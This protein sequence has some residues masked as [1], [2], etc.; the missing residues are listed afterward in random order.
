LAAMTQSE[1]VFLW[2]YKDEVHD[3]SYCPPKKWW[4]T[5]RDIMNMVL[6][7]GPHE[8]VV[9]TNAYDGREI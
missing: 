2:P 3:M 6:D 7:L 4:E 9:I 1:Y 5:E 8:I